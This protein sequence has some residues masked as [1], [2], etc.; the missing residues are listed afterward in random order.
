MAVLFQW[1]GT[2]DDTT[3]DSGETISGTGLAAGGGDAGSDTSSLQDLGDR[4]AI[5]GLGAV[6][7]ILEQSGDAVLNF[8]QGTIYF[9][10]F[11]D[12]N[13]VTRNIFGF[14]TGGGNTYFYGQYNSA[15]R[16]YL[17]MQD[18]S[19]HSVIAY[20]S[21]TPTASQFY[22]VRLT[23]DNDSDNSVGV[24]FDG[25]SF[26]ITSQSGAESNLVISEFDS[27]YFNIGTRDNFDTFD[28]EISRFLISDVY[29][30][31]TLGAAAGGAEN[32]MYYLI[33]SSGGCQ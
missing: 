5:T 27:T 13:N 14:Y 8:N 25:D 15:N 4:M 33:N 7:S 23:F 10:F 28:G 16:L 22:D 24:S 6:S 12:T 32:S 3:A 1:E 31:L 26:A 18:A 30:D 20:R 11:F 21:W 29:E 17:Y 9:R 2:Y 19:S